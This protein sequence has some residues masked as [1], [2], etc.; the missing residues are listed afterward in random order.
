MGNPAPLGSPQ[1]LKQRR[2]RQIRMLIVLAI[3][4]VFSMVCI[5]A[6]FGAEKAGEN[7]QQQ[8]DHLGKILDGAG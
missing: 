5:A 2:F 8:I 3:I 6:W 7:Q 1:E 4:V